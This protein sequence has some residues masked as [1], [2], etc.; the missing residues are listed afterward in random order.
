MPYSLQKEETQILKGCAILLMLLLHLFNAPSRLDGNYLYFFIQGVPLVSLLTRCANPV[1]FFVLLSGY[2]LFIS[3]KKGKVSNVA[4]VKKL[5]IKYWMTLAVFVTIG[6][7]TGVSRYTL[8]WSVLLENLSGYHTTYNEETWF[9]L[10]YV[11]LALTSKYLFRLIDSVR[12][13]LVVSLSLLL[14][15]LALLYMKHKGAAFYD[16]YLMFQPIMYINLQFSFVLGALAA[17]Q[18]WFGIVKALAST[19]A[20]KGLTG[21]LLIALVGARLCIKTAHLDPFY[22][23]LFC[24]LFIGMQRIDGIDFILKKL[25]DNS[26]YMW[27]VHTYFCY[28][29][30]G[31]YLY[32]LKYT[33]LMFIVLVGIS[34][35][36]SLLFLQ[37]EKLI[38]QHP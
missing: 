27:F 1:S 23:M 31:P 19:P 6:Y 4:R 35:V 10:P 17:K 37:I 22:D 16:E 33:G 36:V 15:L 28:Y 7:F 3:F 25:G 30:W 9:L 26:T 38:W 5:Y 2:G 12:P 13:L 24:L 14:Y 21:L 20:R 32:G 11:L 18:N 34:Y 8:S 29:L